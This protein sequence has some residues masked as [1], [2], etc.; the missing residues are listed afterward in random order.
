MHLSLPVGQRNASTTTRVN[1]RQNN[2]YRR[3]IATAYVR[4]KRIRTTTE[5]WRSIVGTISDFAQALARKSFARSR[6]VI[7]TTSP[8]EEDGQGLG[9]VASFSR[10]N[11]GECSF[12]WVS[13]TTLK[14]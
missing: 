1:L 7:A 8:V 2:R 11:Y 9:Y 10:N 5:Q 13:V 14:N 6:P 4:G 12:A 3:R